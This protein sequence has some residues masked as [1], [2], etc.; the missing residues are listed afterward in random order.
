[1]RS[2]DIQHGPL[3]EPTI[4]VGAVGVPAQSAVVPPA[5]HSELN[6]AAVA[7]LAQLVGHPVG[8]HGVGRVCGAAG[9]GTGRGGHRGGVSM[10][11]M[12]L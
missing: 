5:E 7:Q 1:M 10:F 6:L 4:V 9:G 12:M 3:E 2:V 11:V 8:A